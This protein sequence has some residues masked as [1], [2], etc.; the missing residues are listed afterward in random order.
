MELA[1]RP[2]AL[3][4]EH[5]A[6]GF[7]LEPIVLGM[8]VA[9]SREGAYIAIGIVA[10][11]LVRQPLRLAM[12][13]RQQRKRYPRTAAC[14]ALAL[15][16][17]TVAAIAFAMAGIAPLLPLIAA[18]PL[19]AIQFTLDL[20]NHGRTLTAELC[21]GLAAGAT[22]TAIALAA[23]LPLAYALTLWALLALRTVPSILYV[24][25][26]LRGGSRAPMLA[27]HAGAV[28]AAALLAQFAAL[29]MLVLFARAWPP[30]DGMR[31]RDIGIR[32]V[33]Y[34]VVT[35]ALLTIA[36]S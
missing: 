20:R 11:F 2:L 23:S 12:H 35:V 7:L 15:A 18:L 3:P 21:G 4:F 32:E 28:I 29:P 13:D 8:L 19:A 36:V 9:P 27:A 26:A 34:G 17:G 16:Y 33:V 6:W 5:G 14:E 31:A 24:R 10:A 1:L 25:A 22:A 30:A